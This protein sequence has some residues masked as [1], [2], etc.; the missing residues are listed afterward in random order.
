V[1]AGATVIVVN[2]NGGPNLAR[3]LE[4]LIA[5]AP[6]A[7]V[8]VVDNASTDG[9]A[10]LPPHLAPA[11]RLIRNPQNI[12]Y[13]AALNQAAAE[14]RTDLLV[15]SN[16]DTL[17][18]PGW[19]EPLVAFLRDRTDAG[20]V[21]PL[22]VLADG[23]R[24]NAAGQDVHVTGLGFNRGLGEPIERYGT[25]PFEVAGIQGA[26]FVMRRQVYQAI[27]GLDAGGF[28]YHEDVNVSWLLRLAGYRLYCVPASHVRHDYFL[29]MYAEKFHLLERNRVAMLLAY[30]RPVTI[31]L[32]LPFL[33]LTESFA[34]GYALIRR[35]GFIGAKWRSYR[36]IID[37]HS[38]I[39]SRRTL[40]AQLR[41]VGDLALLR[42]LSWAY[43]W[44]QFR[45]L[46]RERGRGRREPGT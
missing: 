20:A 29:S 21:N 39:S 30:L 38:E 37:H 36:W 18:D 42:S 28:L 11:V 14:A 41:R 6:D 16:M 1:S 7:A 12:G 4:S 9:S 13:A 46:A 44:G 15:F 27:G 19:L 8:V 31:I 43:D 40:A 25:A 26:L 24:V 5:T 17:F 3:C 22:I 2:F 34:W 33:L 10:D 35:H 32:L 45:V 23:D